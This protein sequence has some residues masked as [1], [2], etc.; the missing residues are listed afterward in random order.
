MRVAGEL[1]RDTGGFGH[2]RVIGRVGQQNARTIAIEA[3]R[4]QH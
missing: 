2:L 3:N 4:V 1:Q